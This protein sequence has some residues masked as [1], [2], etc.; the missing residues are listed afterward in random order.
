MYFVYVQFL[1]PSSSIR[2][3]VHAC[4]CVCVCVCDNDGV[5][6]GL[7]EGLEEVFIFKQCSFFLFPH[8]KCNQ[9]RRQRFCTTQDW[10]VTIT[11]IPSNP[12]VSYTI[13]TFF[14][15]AVLLSTHKAQP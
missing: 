12:I 15:A 1:V 11:P 14:Y 10:F 7:G 5:M 13:V 9:F 6:E 2:V 8:Y 4:V 3:H